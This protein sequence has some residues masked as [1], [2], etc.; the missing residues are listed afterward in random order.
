MVENSCRGKKPYHR[1]QTN[2][3]QPFSAKLLSQ[4]QM[5][6]KIIKSQNAVQIMLY[7]V[8]CCTAVLFT[9][10]ADILERTFITVNSCYVSLFMWRLFKRLVTHVTWVR[11]VFTMNSAVNGKLTACFKALTANITVIRSLVCMSSP[12][13]SQITGTGERLRTICALCTSLWQLT[14]T[15]RIMFLTRLV[16]TFHRSQPVL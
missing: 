14:A 2:A 15:F 9:F 13:P 1:K 3:K 12:V 6:C 4:Y 10:I 8:F 5:Q 11:F 7:A 16:S